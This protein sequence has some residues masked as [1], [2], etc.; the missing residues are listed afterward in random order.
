MGREVNLAKIIT[1]NIQQRKQAAAEAR[2]PASC[3]TAGIA[4]IPA[5]IYPNIS[6]K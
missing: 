5:P 6:G 2:N 4:R 1:I 3:V